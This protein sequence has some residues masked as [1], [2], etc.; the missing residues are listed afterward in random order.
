MRRAFLRVHYGWLLACLS[1]MLATAG[2]T[3]SLSEPEAVSLNQYAGAPVVRI[4]APLINATY[5]D[6]LTVNAQVTVL[7]AGPDIQ[8]VEIL[9][10]D[11]VIATLP[12][13]NPTGAAVFGVTQTLPAEGIGVH[14]LGAR[15]FRADETVSDPIQVSYL[16]V[17]ES[18]AQ[19][20]SSATPTHTVS[21]MPTTAEVGASTPVTTTQATVTVTRQATATQTLNPQTTPATAIATS[22]TPNQGSPAPAPVANFEGIV[23]VR[24]G[25]SVNFDPP[26]G[27]FQAG[28]SAEILGLNTDGSWLKV[29]FAN[30]EGWVFAQIA[31]TTGDLTTLPR[32]TGPA[33]PFPPAATAT[34]AVVVQPPTQ[35]ASTSEPPA[36]TDGA[37]LVVTAIEL[38]MLN[39]GGSNIIGSGQPSIAFVRVRNAGNQ[40]AVGFFAVLTIVNQSDSGAKIVEAGAV[41]GLQPGE[42]QLIQIGFTDTT[43]TGTVRVAVVRLD[44]NNQAPETN[45]DD[46]ASPPVVYTLQ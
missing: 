6:G 27:T 11:V 28:Q 21:P 33:T 5:I 36:P 26:L 39:G 29:R 31:R 9:L 7:N 3:L 30:G 24:R 41:S 43:A 46:N 12:D 38:R 40:P 25:P 45:E 23:N 22:G 17:D 8:R 34:S 16:V 2:C 19:V 18:A 10:D 15:A 14:T 32:E 13:P 37:N 35:A 20:A 42:E 4:A 44:E 1:L